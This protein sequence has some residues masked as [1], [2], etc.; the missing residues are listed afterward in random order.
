VVLDNAPENKKDC[1]HGDWRD[2]T[3]PSFDSE[4]ECRQFVQGDNDNGN[5]HSHH[6]DD[7]DGGWYYGFINFWKKFF[8]WWN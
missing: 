3:E 1:K 4:R 7:N 5:G 8:G 2:F 6:D